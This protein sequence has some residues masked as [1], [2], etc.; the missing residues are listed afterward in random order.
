M[1]V[2]KA[3]TPQVYSRPVSVMAATIVSPQATAL[4]S[5]GSPETA[6]SSNTAREGARFL[7]CAL[8]AFS[9]EPRYPAI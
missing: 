1:A 9:V 4:I 7:D 6:S 3:F 2:E 8:A 5:L